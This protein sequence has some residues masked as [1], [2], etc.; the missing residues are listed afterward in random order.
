MSRTAIVLQA[1]MG[2]ARLPG[3]VLAQVAGRTV[4]AHC[5]ERLQACSGLPV[6]V[7]TTDLPDDDRLVAEALRLGTTV[8]RG[9]AEDVLARYLQ[10]ASQLSLTEIVRASADNPAVDMDAPRRTLEFLR[11]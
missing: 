9:A 4:L 1:C 2:S 8:V 11:R 7:A 6:V 5:V 10:A 3:K